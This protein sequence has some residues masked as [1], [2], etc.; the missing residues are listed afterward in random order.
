MHTFRFLFCYVVVIS[1]AVHVAHLQ[2]CFAFQPQLQLFMRLLLI[3]VAFRPRSSGREQSGR[4]VAR[5]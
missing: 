1:D 4:L 3:C 2:G 5:D